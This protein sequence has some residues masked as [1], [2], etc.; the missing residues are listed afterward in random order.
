MATPA[1]LLS[2]RAFGAAAVFTAC[3]FGQLR[4]ARAQPASGTDAGFPNR[5]V[6]LVV[7]APP[8]TAPDVRARQLAQKLSEEWRQT[9]FVDNRP[10]ATGNIAME[11][12]SRAAPDGYTLAMI[13]IQQAINPHLMKIPYDTLKDFVPVSK[14]TAGP[15]ILLVNAATPA[16]TLAELVRH[17]RANPGK[18]NLATGGLGSLGHLGIIVFNKAAGTEF[19]IVPYKGGGTQVYTDL[20]GNQVQVTWDLASISMPYLSTGRVKAL[21]VAAE[22]RLAVLPDVPTF[23]ELGYPDIQLFGWQG[24]AVPAGTPPDL[25]RFLNRAIVKVL[26]LPDVR[27]AIT[28][29]GA[30]IGGDT[31]EQFAAYIRA[32]HARWGK[33]IADA[34]IRL[35]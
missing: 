32:E 10:S 1:L 21:A 15:L 26:N 25:V 5:P 13:N 31:P 27:E 23:Q 28:A 4:G 8:G 30:E 3:G 14:V 18:L 16:G 22:K 2:R 11:F 34:G 19:T 7:P 12:A 6:R 20:V 24:I 29:T 33:L 9:V 17:A 35:E